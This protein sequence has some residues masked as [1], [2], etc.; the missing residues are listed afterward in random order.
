MKSLLRGLLVGA[1]LFALSG[2]VSGAEDVTDFKGFAWGTDFDTVDQAKNLKWFRNLGELG[3][4][5]SM[6]DT[7]YDR[8]TKELKIGYFYDF[9]SNKLVSGMIFFGDKSQY[10]EAIKM[11]EEK[12]GKS[13]Y[14]NERVTYYSLG[15]TYISCNSEQT[16]ITFFSTEYMNDNVKRKKEAE[17]AKKDKDFDRLFN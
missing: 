16:T 8:E 9:Y 5:M 12:F 7:E 14:L 6:E 15:R 4:H 13:K 11:L 17:K 1:L 3:E 10:L 2:M